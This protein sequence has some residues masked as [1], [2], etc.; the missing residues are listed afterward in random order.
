MLRVLQ[1]LIYFFCST[2]AKNNKLEELEVGCPAFTRIFCNSSSIPDTYHS[3]NTLG[4]LGNEANEECWPEGLTSSLQVN[5]DT[6]KSQAARMK[7]IKTHCSM[8]VYRHRYPK[9][10]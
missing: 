8:L 10:L 9:V 2:L 7:I 6:S 4:E 3:K 5:A 1:N